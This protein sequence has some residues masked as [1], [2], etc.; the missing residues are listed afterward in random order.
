MTTDEPTPTPTISSNNETQTNSPISEDQALSIAMPIIQQYAEENN[1][2]IGNVT[3]YSYS[4]LSSKRNLVFYYVPTNGSSWYIEAGFS[5]TD[6]VHL[7]PIDS[8]NPQQWICGYQVVIMA[9][10]G[11]I[12]DDRTLGYF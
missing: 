3:A 11:K 6:S 4:E 12:V 8:S 5:P 2:T 10:T 9:D 1:R 7:N